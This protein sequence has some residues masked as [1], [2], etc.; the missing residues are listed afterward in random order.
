[1]NPSMHKTCKYLATALAASAITLAAASV[2]YAAEPQSNAKLPTVVTPSD[3]SVKEKLTDGSFVEKAALISMKD[4]ELAKLAVEKSQNKKLKKFAKKVAASSSSS[5]QQLKQV[6]A[7]YRLEV[8]QQLSSD[9]RKMIDEMRQLSGPK[10]DQSYADVMKKS[11]DTTVGLYDNAAGQNTLNAELRVF[12]NKQL[13]LLRQNQKLAHA[14][15][16][17]A[18]TTAA[19]NKGKA[20][21]TQKVVS[22]Q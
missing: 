7:A 16:Q 15:S 1:M 8:P 12:A 13:P 2:G 6:A 22:T 14:L 21:A 4:M 18:P 5:M 10:F 9:Q 3:S 11:Q 17:T 19:I 20:G